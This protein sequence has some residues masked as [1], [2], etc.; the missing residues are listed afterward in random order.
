MA[1]TPFEMELRSL[2]SIQEQGHASTTITVFILEGR[3]PGE[4]RLNPNPTIIFLWTVW[5][6]QPHCP[7]NHWI[8]PVYSV[9]REQI[10]WR[11]VQAHNFPLSTSIHRLGG[12]FQSRVY[13]GLH[14]VM[15]KTC[16]IWVHSGIWVLMKT[17]FSGQRGNQPRLSWEIDKSWRSLISVQHDINWWQ[18]YLCIIVHSN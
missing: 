18:F 6:L 5:H 11:P 3:L 8:F 16:T 12:A 13:H 1:L 10:Q 14:T 7:V 15:L 4:L 9:A 17:C 2:T